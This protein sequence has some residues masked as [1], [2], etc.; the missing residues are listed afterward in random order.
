[1][2]IITNI[3]DFIWGYIVLFII[4]IG[5]FYLTFKNRFVQF[6]R[7]RLA[8]K[9]MFFPTKKAKG[10]VSSFAA[11]CTALGATVGVGNIVGVATAVCAGGPG[12]LF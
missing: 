10:D 8:L 6:G 12:A 5:G 9:L 4:F 11:L 2:E 7:I 1:M 3:D